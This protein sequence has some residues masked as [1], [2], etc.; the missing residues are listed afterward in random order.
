MYV[1]LMSLLC[2]GQPLWDLCECQV[3]IEATAPLFVIYIK[4]GC[5]L[6]SYY[7]M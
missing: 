1:S 7:K 4:K 6:D 5:K 3:I 2:I